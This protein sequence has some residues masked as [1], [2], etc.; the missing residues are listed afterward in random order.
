MSR[1]CGQGRHRVAILAAREQQPELRSPSRGG[2]GGVWVYVTQYFP[3]SASMCSYWAGSS[4]CTTGNQ[5]I[6]FYY[7]A[8]AQASGSAYHNTAADG[9]DFGSNIPPSMWLIRRISL[10]VRTGAGEKG[11]SG[12]AGGRDCGIGVVYGARCEHDFA[13]SECGAS[14][15]TPLGYA[16][17]SGH[18]PR[19]VRAVA[20]H[21]VRRMLLIRSLRWTRSLLP[22][23]RRA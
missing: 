8:F 21:A 7:H 4:A 3:S 12:Y 9:A 15:G 1:W 18:T 16:G 17:Q 23:T 5:N 11:P 6:T 22:C 14:S 20:T 13:V 10:Y 2:G 19:P